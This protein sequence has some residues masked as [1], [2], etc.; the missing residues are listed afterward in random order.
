MDNTVSSLNLSRDP[1]MTD[2]VARLCRV[3]SHFSKGI[4]SVLSTY[5]EPTSVRKQIFSITFL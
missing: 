1:I 5:L 2:T 3:F 4:N